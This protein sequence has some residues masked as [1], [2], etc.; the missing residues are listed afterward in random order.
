[1]RAWYEQ[2]SPAH[3][4]QPSSDLR[5]WSTI[6]PDGGQ[7][8]CH[9]QVKER[10]GVHTRRRSHRNHE[11]NGILLGHGPGFPYDTQLCSRRIGWMALSVDGFPVH[12]IGAWLSIRH[13]WRLSDY[14]QNLTASSLLLRFF[15]YLL[16]SPHPQST[17]LGADVL[18]YP[19]WTLE[20]V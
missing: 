4:T 12:S 16:L 15:N 1:L 11:T 13:F 14:Q 8:N 9:Q 2:A 10:N 19:S 7:P 18:E 6:L 20:S 3:K 17:M 5:V